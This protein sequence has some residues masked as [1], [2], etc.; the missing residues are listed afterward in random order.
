MRNE[1]KQV[2]SN[3]QKKSGSPALIGITF[4]LPNLW[5]FLHLLHPTLAP[6]LRTA[7][8]PL[9]TTS[10]QEMSTTHSPKP[11]PS[12]MLAQPVTTALSDDSSSKS[13]PLW[14]NCPLCP[15]LKHP[16]SDFSRCPFKN[17]IVMLKQGRDS[18]SGQHK[19]LQKDLMQTRM[20]I[21]EL[22]SAALSAPEVPFSDANDWDDPDDKTPTPQT[23][24]LI[25]PPAIPPHPS[26]FQQPPAFSATQ[27]AAFSATQAA[28]S[29][30]KATP[31]NPQNQ[32][33][34]FAFNSSAYQDPPLPN[35]PST[36]D[37]NFASLLQLLNNVYNSAQQSQQ[38]PTTPIIPPKS[39][40]HPRGNEICTL[41]PLIPSSTIHKVLLGTFTI[42]DLG[43]FHTSS[44]ESP[45]PSVA[46]SMNEDG[47]FVST[48]HLSKA[49]KNLSS[50][51]IML[52]CISSY[53]AIRAFRILFDTGS[54]PSAL[55]S[56]GNSLFI[57]QLLAWY[58]TASPQDYSFV[59][60]KQYA[61]AVINISL[62][63]LSFDYSIIRENIYTRCICLR[64]NAS[65]FNSS[66]SSQ[67]NQKSDSN[68]K[69]KAKSPA[70]SLT[71]NNWNHN[72]PR[73]CSQSPCKY[74]HACSACGGPHSLSSCT[75]KET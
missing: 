18:F 10:Q 64:S 8:C 28:T 9:N 75:T 50:F 1:L 21:V 7:L 45:A 13:G 73:P 46:F 43:S 38:H 29:N 54:N 31:P 71:C 11:K 22:T 27:A 63:D 12:Q 49:Q 41:Y 20:N 61:L 3:E 40:E 35:L 30:A 42:S 70:N 4:S 37:A 32:N 66:R 24:T 36:S 59:G 74:K 57:Q 14:F 51:P 47:H 6:A 19:Q 17:D 65:S 55:I 39:K 53:L 34:P 67:N 5:I 58:G 23:V 26:N 62:N 68:N 25:P 60:I 15:D 48:D 33:F 16:M 44:L 72:P 56:A 2:K 52:K 69:G